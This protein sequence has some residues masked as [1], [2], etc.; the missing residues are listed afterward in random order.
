MYA[1]RIL[2][3]CEAYEQPTLETFD[4]ETIIEATEPQDKPFNELSDH[5]SRRRLAQ[6]SVL[7]YL[8]SCRDLYSLFVHRPD[9]SRA[10]CSP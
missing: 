2:M 3:T 1:K 10:S 7:R 6:A 4:Y 5:N 8:Q 9:R